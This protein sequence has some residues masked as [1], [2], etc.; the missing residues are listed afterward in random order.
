MSAQDFPAACVIGWPIA[1]SRSPLIHNFWLAEHRIRA[2]YEKIAVEPQN[3]SAFLRLMAARGMRGCNVTVPHKEAAFALV[4]EADDTA[5]AVGAVNTI[6]LEGDRLIGA[7]TDV[8]G[9]LANLD[10][11]AAGWRRDRAIVLGAGGAGRGIAYALKSRGVTEV[12][13][14]NRTL[15]RAEEVAQVLGR[16]VCARRIEDLPGLLENADL[17][18]NT[19]SL[20]M[21]GQP[22]LAMDLAPLPDHAVV[23]DIVYAPLETALLAAARARGLRAVDG[24]GMLLQQAAPGF[25]NW[26]GVRP[27]VTPALRDLIVADLERPAH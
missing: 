9:F 17:V 16:G 7:N 10:D 24:L 11:Q 22:P 14:V 20:G 4:D 27:R 3:L 8:P 6:W 5:R 12:E 25:E 18:V 19:T 26:F 23:A 13:I 2:R 1:H 15:E 21:T